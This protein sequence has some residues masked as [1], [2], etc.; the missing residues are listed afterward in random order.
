MKRHI[1]VLSAALA[2]S[3]CSTMDDMVFWEDDEPATQIPPPPTNPTPAQPTMS[4][5]PAPDLAGAGPAT[6]V[7]MNEISTTGVG[8]E[9]GTLTLRD[10]SGGLAITANL[11]DLEPGSHGFHVHQNPN[12]APAG[13][14]GKMQ[15]GETAGPHFDPE[16]TG[17]HLGP[18][19]PGHKGDMPLL[20]VA[21]DGTATGTVVVPRL[22][23]ADVQRR[24]I[25]IH[26]GGDNFSDKP[27]PN[28]GSGNRVACGIV[29]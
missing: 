18:A 7:T 20:T 2:L 25:I 5:A 23:V 28:G 12:C 11:A 17:K 3:A 13:K 16:K 14:D 27:K 15:A 9:I 8:T 19:K 1:L 21:E 29:Q 10:T 6:T 22:K 24:S 4:A 26:A